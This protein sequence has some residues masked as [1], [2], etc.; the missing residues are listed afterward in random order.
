M[1]GG[2]EAKAQQSNRSVL[3]SEL[4]ELRSP[5]PPQRAPAIWLVALGERLHAAR[6]RF[7]W[8]GSVLDAFEVLLERWPTRYRT[9]YYLATGKA[10]KP[11]SDAAESS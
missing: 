6:D 1:A 5:A 3:R 7:C 9:G 10:E 11:C 2:F 8:L 4:V